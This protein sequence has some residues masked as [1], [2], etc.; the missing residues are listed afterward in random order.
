LD[1]L[2]RLLAFSPSCRPSVEEAL[3]HPYLENYYDPQDEP[4]A[5]KP[6]SFEVLQVVTVFLF[7]YKKNSFFS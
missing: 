7:L 1:L 2:D 4:V 5:E 3:A 6:F